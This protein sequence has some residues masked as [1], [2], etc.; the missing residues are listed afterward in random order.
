MLHAVLHDQLTFLLVLTAATALAGAAALV[1]ARRRGARGPWWGLTAA[2]AVPVLGAT[3]FF[4]GRQTGA[5]ARW[6]TINKQLLEPMVTDQGVLNAVLFVPFAFFGVLATRRPVP[7]AVAGAGASLVIEVG[8][9]LSGWMGGA[10]DSGDVQMNTLGTLLGVGFAA[11]LGRVRGVRVAW[12]AG[13]RHAGMAAVGVLLVCGSAFALFIRPQV[14]DGTELR[15]ALSGERAA[16][17]QAVREA[18]GDRYRISAVQHAPGMEGYG[19]W[20]HIT[21]AEPVTAMLTWPDKQV[22]TAELDESS[23]TGPTAFPVSAP[24]VTPLTQGEAGRLAKA[25]AAQHYPWS[26]RGVTQVETTAVGESAEQGWITSW[27]WA[28]DGVLMPRA[29]DVRINRAGRVTQLVVN[30]GPDH[31][32]GLGEMKVTRGAAE[33]KVAEK[34]RGS[35][36][37][38]VAQTCRVYRVDG[39]WRALWLVKVQAAAASDSMVMT[40]DAVSGHV[41]HGQPLG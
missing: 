22:F 33:A 17:E 28:E 6:C 37:T 36:D 21:F 34:L 27:R 26:A 7:V 1:L 20:L 13:A 29:L 24:E 9:S 4:P 35:A 16:A 12:R 19:A 23:I 3:L 10:C 25:Y 2:S 30:N 8:Q 32:D 41:G 39:E 14:M 5:S 11:V 38:V 40:V 15:M 31:V 18:F